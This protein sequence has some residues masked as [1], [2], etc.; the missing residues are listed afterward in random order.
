MRLSDRNLLILT[1]SLVL[2]W[3]T[4]AK[5]NLILLML[6]LFA[7][8]HR[9]FSMLKSTLFPEIPRLMLLLSLLIFF[10]IADL[11]GE[12]KSEIDCQRHRHRERHQQQH[13]HHNNNNIIKQHA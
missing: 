10:S 8:E 9:R 6:L 7:Y 4:R 2:V 13:Q 3:K 5:I 12:K 11:N 1:I